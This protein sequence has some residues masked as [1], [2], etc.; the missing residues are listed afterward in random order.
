MSLRLALPLAALLASPLVVAAAAYG[1]RLEG[2]DYDFPVRQFAFESQQ[3]PLEMAYLDVAPTGR[4]NGRTVVLLHG[5]NFCAGTWAD[6]IRTLSAAG[7]RVVAPDQIG[8]CKSTKPAHY[9]YSFQQLA[10]NTH[11]LL[12]HLGIA[13]VTLIGHSTG[14]MLATRYALLYPDT[15]EQ[16][17]LVNPIG[18]EDWK[19]L[20][21][22]YRSVDQWY[23]RELKTSAAG[24]RDYER[25]TYYAGQ[26]SP[27]Y[28]RWVDMLA[29][30]NAVPGKQRVAWNS[31]LL[32]DMIYT[33]PVVY[34]FDQLHMPTLLLIGQRDTTAIG[35]DAAP[36][37]VKARLGHYPELGRAAAKRIPHATLVE[38]DDL[39]HAPQMQAPERFHQALLQGLQALAK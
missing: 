2:F 8:F 30:L 18:L 36:P 9:Q 23:A 26:W 24:I 7:Y 16:L 29:G 27:R 11:A 19:A 4:A 34:E 6:S 21:V 20:G 32:Y 39:G 33:Q 14:G 15:T 12:D 17:V 13:K 31:A 10:A 5:K 1:E 28:E 22:P 25:T 38:F 37:E 35:K 3:Q